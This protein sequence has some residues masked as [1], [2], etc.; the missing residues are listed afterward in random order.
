MKLFN[1]KEKSYQE[2][3][4]MHSEAARL[5]DRIHHLILVRDDLKQDLENYPDE[6]SESMKQRLTE[7]I[8]EKDRR[9]KDLEK[10]LNILTNYVK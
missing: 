7:S 8:K 4:T 9:V 6:Y 2:L 3:A 5:C 10:Q 1:Q